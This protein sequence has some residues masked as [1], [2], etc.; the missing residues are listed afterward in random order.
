ML[1]KKSKAIIA[2]ALSAA[3]VS[4]VMVATVASAA[5]TRTKP[6]AFGED[7]YAERFLSLYDDVV[8]NGVENGYLS[9][10]GSSSSAFGIPFHSVE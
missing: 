9:K 2:A 3:V 1:F 10:N 8:T 5:G 6:E 4:N 7:T